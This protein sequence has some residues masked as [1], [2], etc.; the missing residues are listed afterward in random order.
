MSDFDVDLFVI[1][2]GSGGV[3]AARIAAGH[4]ARVMLAEEFRMGGTCVVRG[5]IPKKL[6]VYAARFQD[7]F[8]DAAGFGWSVPAPQ[9]DWPALIAAKDREIARLEGLYTTGQVNAGV[10]VVKSRAVFE[11]AHTLRLVSD[12]SRIRARH[13]L[14]ATG[15]R[16]DM[17]AIPGIE[18]AISSNEALDLKH[19]PKRILIAGAGYI[20]LEFAGIFAGLGSEV[21]VIY[22]GDKVLRGFD[23]DLRDALTEAYRRR[24]IKFIFN[25]V[26]ER[27]EAAPDA[28][29]GVVAVT[30]GGERLAVDQVMFAIGRS[31]NTAGL[32]LEAAGVVTGKRGAVKVD[33]RSQSSVPHIYAVGDVTDRVNLTPV[34]IREGHAFADSVFGG[35]PWQVEHA[36]IATAVFSTPEI[37]T[38]G[39]SEEQARARYRVVDIYKTD[40]RPLKATLS[41]S[42]DRMLMKLV[43]D[44][45]SDGVLGVH[46]L[47]ED[48]GEMAQLLGIAVK[49]RLTKAQFDETMAVHPTA[50]EELVTM[51]SRTARYQ[52]TEPVAAI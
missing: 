14:I 9:F 8:E 37:G 49:A 1:G 43:V 21:T 38:V 41:G 31:P 35:K 22:R 46:I 52:R 25:D 3:R 45:E 44:G 12:G 30:L 18:R 15:G 7:A 29:A 32:G 36:D 39:L 5:C 6:L 26:V 33:A 2:G 24:G 42:Q 47:G 16:P 13:V 27:L 48:A 20:A 19:L 34:A 28:D 11:D 10:T 17:P 40:F 4:G 23:E 50:A 51:R